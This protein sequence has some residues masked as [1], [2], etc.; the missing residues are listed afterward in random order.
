MLA[1][2]SHLLALRILGNGFQKD[3]LCH[4]LK[5]GSEADYFVVPCSFL[6]RGVMLAF[7]KSSGTSPDH[8]DLSKMS[9]SSLTMTLTSSLS[10]LG[11]IPSHLMDLCISDLLKHSLIP[12]FSTM[13]NVLFL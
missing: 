6:K 2:P 3:L 8:C 1:V 7:F 10:S 4:H 12:S 11:F 13:S 5:D 9:E